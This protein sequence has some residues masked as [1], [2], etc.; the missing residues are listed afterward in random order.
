[1]KFIRRTLNRQ[2]LETA[3]PWFATEFSIQL[4]RNLYTV[5]VLDLNFLGG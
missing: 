1:M 2:I 4:G 3:R 5:A